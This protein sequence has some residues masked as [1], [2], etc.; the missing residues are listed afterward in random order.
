[1]IFTKIICILRQ[2]ESGP[3]V[4]FQYCCQMLLMV[5]VNSKKCKN[6]EVCIFETDSVILPT[7]IQMLPFTFWY[8]LNRRKLRKKGTSS[9]GLTLQI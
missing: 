8:Y 1:M 3:K 2:A 7:C 4:S 6:V 5:A 9:R